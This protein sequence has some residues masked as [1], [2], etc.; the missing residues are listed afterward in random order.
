MPDSVDDHDD[1]NCFKNFGYNTIYY[2]PSITYR[3]PKNSNGTDFLASNTSYTAAKVN[4]FSSSSS[5]TNL[6]DTTSQSVTTAVTV[7]L[8]N[9][10]FTTTNGS[11]NVT[12]THTAHGLADGTRV[13]FSGVPNFNGIS[14]SGNYN[15]T[16]LSANTYRIRV[17]NNANRNGSGGGANVRA[18]YNVT[19]TTQSP[20]TAGTS[21]RPTPTSPPTTCAADS[22][23]TWRSPST[24]AERLNFTN[25]YSY[26]RTRILMM[27]S[28]T[29][30]A[31]AT[32]DDKFRVGYTAISETGTGS[33]GFLK[34]A[35]FDSTAQVGLVHE[36]VQR[37][38]SV[39]HLLYAVA[40]R[41]L[42]GRAPVRRHAGDG[43]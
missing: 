5:T 2:N 13:T 36:A 8:G 14:I 18:Q 42:E 40:R 41:A 31:F 10:P 12:V 30:R 35:K 21:T 3:V 34:I 25:W 26:Y 6:S 39:R 38:L 22:A 16:Y 33:S 11:R 24:A 19:T 28:A 29:G 20:T 17:G 7:T 32:V 23:Y 37:R 9:N 1:D 4:G 15:I 43:Q 27:K